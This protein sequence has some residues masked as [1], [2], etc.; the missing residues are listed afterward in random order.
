MK[1]QQCLKPSSVALGDSLWEGVYKYMN[2]DLRRVSNENSVVVDFDAFKV[3]RV[4]GT[5]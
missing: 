2:E 5:P 3:S 4:S 1:S